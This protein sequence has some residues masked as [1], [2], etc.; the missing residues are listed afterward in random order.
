MRIQFDGP[1]KVGERFIQLADFQLV[2][3]QLVKDVPD[4]FSARYLFRTDYGLYKFE[5]LCY[6]LTA[7]SKKVPLRG[8]DGEVYR[9]RPHAFRHTVGTQMLNSGMSIIDVMTYLDH[10][11]PMMTLNYTR[12]SMRR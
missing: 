7:L 6:Q 10:R 5:S 4:H 8:P 9:L 2:R 12:Y 1:L 3:S 11:S